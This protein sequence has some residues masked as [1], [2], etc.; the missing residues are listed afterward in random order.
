MRTQ[1]T[2][3]VLTRLGE[4]TVGINNGSSVY[5]MNERIIVNGVDYYTSG[6]MGLVDGV[7]QMLDTFSIRKV[8]SF[9]HSDYSTSAKQKAFEMLSSAISYLLQ[10]GDT[11]IQLLNEA[12][13][14]YI[15]ER[16][17]A[18]QSQI[19]DKQK[20]IDILKAQIDALN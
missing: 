5:F 12:Q 11:A 14:E 18:L 1:H 17:E 9:R 8:N 16:R 13:K 4:I 15:Q 6:H 2:F 20:E 19:D 3:K 7:W 10:N